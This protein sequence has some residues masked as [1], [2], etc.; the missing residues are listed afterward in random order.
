MHNKVIHC[1]PHVLTHPPKEAQK[2]RPPW[3]VESCIREEASAVG[4][5]S[6]STLGCSPLTSGPIGISTHFLQKE[7]KVL[8]CV[9]ICILD[10][11]AL[12]LH[13]EVYT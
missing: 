3:S 8:V 4:F 7:P 10:S 5:L 12:I 6:I 11:M 1:V 13:S 2:C 9:G